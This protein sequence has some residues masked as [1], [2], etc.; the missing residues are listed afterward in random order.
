MREKICKLTGILLMKAASGKMK[1]CKTVLKNYYQKKNKK[2]E[3]RGFYFV[4]FQFSA[5]QER[6]AALKLV[7]V[8]VSVQWQLTL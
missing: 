5:P 8:E 7:T 2:E 3:K 4:F 6:K 1:K